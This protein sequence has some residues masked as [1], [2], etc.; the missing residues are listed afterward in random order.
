MG[1]V[2]KIRSKP[3]SRVPIMIIQRLSS[4]YGGLVLRVVPTSRVLDGIAISKTTPG[5]GMLESNITRV[6]KK[7]YPDESLVQ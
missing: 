6:C 3:T 4:G 1:P 2:K 7:Y 5:L